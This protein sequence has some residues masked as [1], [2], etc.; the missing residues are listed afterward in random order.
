MTKVVV[1][2]P[3]YLITCHKPR[4][5]N[6]RKKQAISDDSMIIINATNLTVHQHKLKFHVMRSKHFEWNILANNNDHMIIEKYF[7][8]LL[9]EIPMLMPTVHLVRVEK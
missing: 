1:K 9:L 8:C 2:V 7:C 5:N 4:R 3:R 6:V